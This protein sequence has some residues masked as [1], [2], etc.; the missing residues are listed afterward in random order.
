[1]PQSLT[2]KTYANHDITLERV[3]NFAKTAKI[4][5]KLGGNF[6]LDLPFR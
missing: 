4:T 3:K 6:Y 2:A 5:M 1:M